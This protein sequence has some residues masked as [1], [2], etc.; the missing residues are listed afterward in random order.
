MVVYTPTL[1]DE[2][3]QVVTETTGMDNSHAGELTGDIKQSTCAAPEIPAQL[4]I[5]QSVGNCNR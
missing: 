5:E 1:I 2:P 4:S 3:Q